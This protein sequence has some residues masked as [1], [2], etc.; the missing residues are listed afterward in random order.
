MERGVCLFPTTPQTLRSGRVSVDPSTHKIRGCAAGPARTDRPFA[1][2]LPAGPVSSQARDGKMQRIGPRILD[3]TMV[4]NGTKRCSR[5]QQDA[6]AGHRLQWCATGPVCDS[7][8]RSKVNIPPR[9]QESHRMGRKSGGWV[10][11]AP[12]SVQDLPASPPEASASKVTPLSGTPSPPK[13]KTSAQHCG[14]LPNIST[15]SSLRLHTDTSS[16]S[17]RLSLSLGV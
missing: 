4:E 9:S 17:A 8:P 3:R 10:L 13:A 14:T 1:A 15:H 2:N 7:P 11:Q 12:G 5:M 16:Q 6:D